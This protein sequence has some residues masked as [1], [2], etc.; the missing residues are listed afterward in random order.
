MD[1]GLVDVQKSGYKEA[2]TQLD[3]LKTP[4]RASAWGTIRIANRAPIAVFAGPARWKAARMRL[5]MASALKE[6]AARLGIGLI[7]K[8]SYDKANRTSLGRQARHRAWKA[9]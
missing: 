8:S 3:S 7:Y 4:P 1:S 2:M 9:P 6:I 5:E